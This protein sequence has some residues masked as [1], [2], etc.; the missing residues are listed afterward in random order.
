MV[1]VYWVIY[2][3]IYY[4]IINFNEEDMR[5]YLPEK[6][7]FTEATGPRCISLLSVDKSLRFLKSKSV[8]VLLYDFLT[9]K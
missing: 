5:I 7:I 2:T 1:H 3:G 8:I 4:T 9:M 6:V